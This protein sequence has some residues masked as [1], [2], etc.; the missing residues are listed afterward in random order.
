MLNTIKSTYTVPLPRADVKVL[1]EEFA[2]QDKQ[3]LY[4]FEL[5]NF[6]LGVRFQSAEPQAKRVIVMAML[7]WLDQHSLKSYGHQDQNAWQMGWKMREAFL[8]MLK[9]KIPF[10]EQDV[11][12]I[13]IQ[14]RVSLDR[15]I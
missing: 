15:L 3:R 2:K 10:H 6:R 14:I 13:E 4:P 9:F 12:T 1:V 11:C 8:H 5:Q 7:A